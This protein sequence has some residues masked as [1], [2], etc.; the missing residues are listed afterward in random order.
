MEPSLTISTLLRLL[1]RL[2]GRGLIPTGLHRRPDA[3]LSPARATRSAHSSRTCRA[4]R[5]LYQILFMLTSCD[6]LLKTG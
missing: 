2:R 4:A 5:E 1:A 3:P 6:L